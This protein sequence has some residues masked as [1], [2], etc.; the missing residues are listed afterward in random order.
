[1]EYYIN[2][3]EESQVERKCG[4]TEWRMEFYSSNKHGEHYRVAE[5]LLSKLELWLEKKID[6]KKG[7]KCGFIEILH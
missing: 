3:T 2:Y 4:S 1:M 6:E 7:L 5:S